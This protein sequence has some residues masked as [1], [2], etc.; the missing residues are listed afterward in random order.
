MAVKASS[1]QI[2]ERDAFPAV[3]NPGSEVSAIVLRSPRGRD[4]VVS[5]V[6]NLNQ[7]RRRYGGPDAFHTYGYEA[8]ADYFDAGGSFLYV[9]RVVADDAVKGESELTPVG[10]TTGTNNHKI[11]ASSAGSWANNASYTI[12]KYAT[13]LTA[14]SSSNI[15]TVQSLVGVEVGDIIYV[16]DGSNTGTFIVIDTNVSSKTVTVCPNDSSGN[17]LT[18]PTF[19]SGASVTCATSHKGKTVTTE[20]V[21]VSGSTASI[22]V[23][24]SAG[25]NAG[26]LIL[27]VDPSGNG[28]AEAHVDTV[29]GNTLN[30]TV[31]TTGGLTTLSSGAVIVTVNFPIT[32]TVDGETETY[33]TL[34]ME[35]NDS[36]SYAGTVLS[37]AEFIRFEAGDVDGSGYSAFK[38]PRAVKEVSLGSTTQGT[39]GSIP[40]P[41]DFLGTNPNKN[42]N[43]G[44]ALLDSIQNLSQFGVVG[45]QASE[46][47]YAAVHKGMI[48]YAENRGFVM[49]VLDVPPTVDQLDEL[50]DYRN[51]TLNA[52][53][54]YSALYTPWLVEADAL[55][56]GG[57]VDI[58]P[59]GQV[60]GVYSRVAANRG[61]HK[62]PAN[63]VVGGRVL[64][65]TTVYTDEEVAVMKAAGI[66]P[67]RNISGAGI[68]I[69][70][71]RTLW[72]QAD[73]KQF[74]SVRRVLNAVELGFKNFGFSILQEPNDDVLWKKIETT[75]K[76]FLENLWKNGWFFPRNNADQAF[77]FICDATTNTEDYRRQGIVRAILGINPVL[78][79][80]IALFEVFLYDGG[81]VNINAL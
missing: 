49:A 24:A 51:V 75:G 43:H 41:D 57:V 64:D 56:P 45:M 25:F 33:D 67:I 73:R 17:A 23:A 58:P 80:E 14:N 39:D 9:V 79:G 7:Y 28:V 38:Y 53:T 40:T 18:I 5:L 30:V 78:P 31:L 76:A 15:F 77:V 27:M 66:N 19:S 68:R 71:A 37:G 1:V 26:A 47:D 10:A 81:E 74:I 72:R 32:V 61:P 69:T 52:Q 2:I 55:T 20:D 50:L 54:S 21:D 70:E 65:V 29:T 44:I 4:D 3:Q 42:Y 35:Q 6:S 59:T 36:A 62:A 16:D 22:K 34:S 11:V 13:T 8:V 63:E 48:S 60:L 46:A 12:Q